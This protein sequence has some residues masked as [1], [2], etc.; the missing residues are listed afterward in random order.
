MSPL[1]VENLYGDAETVSKFSFGTI[2]QLTLSCSCLFRVSTFDAF[3][4]N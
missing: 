2:K 3:L 4:I 1:F